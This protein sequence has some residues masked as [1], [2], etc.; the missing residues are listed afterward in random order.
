MSLLAS[1]KDTAQNQPYQRLDNTSSN[2][3]LPIP[4]HHTMP[5]SRQVDSFRILIENRQNKGTER[6]NFSPD[7]RTGPLF[8]FGSGFS[9]KALLPDVG[10]PIWATHIS[11]NNSNYILSLGPSAG[12][13]GAG[14]IEG[15][16]TPV[17]L[18]GGQKVDIAEW[19]IM[20]NPKF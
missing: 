19:T 14:P 8:N 7:L 6:P 12:N 2:L 13:A 9:E 20:A 16:G 4:F 10:K 15:N 3:T 17:A 1:V 18:N 11:H 5:D